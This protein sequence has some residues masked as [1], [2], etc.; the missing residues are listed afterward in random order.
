MLGSRVNLGS[1]ALVCR[2]LATTLNSGVSVERAFELAA[3]KTR[4]RRC[5]DVMQDVKDRV[6][7]GDDIATAMRARPNALPGLMIDLVEVG[8]KTGALPEILRNVAEH[9]ENNLRLRRSFYQSIAWPV[10]QLIAAILV[11]AGVIWLLGVI[12]SSRGGDPIDVLGLGLVG[13]SGAVIWL[14]A[15]FGTIFA[16]LVSYRIAASALEG[17]MFL[18]SLLMHIPVVGGCMR[19]FALARFAWA[20]ALTQQAGMPIKESLD[21]SL[22]ATNNGAFI[23]V[24]PT[25]W[26]LVKQGEPLAEAMAEVGVFPDDF[27]QIVEVAESS[28]TVP[29]ALERLSGQLEED[30][31]RS[32]A[33]LTAVLGWGVWLIVAIFIIFI[34]FNM[35]MRVYIGP[36]YEALDQT[37]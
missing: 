21:A 36:L 12:A 16:L 2:S 29:E 8:E 30:A 4:D 13:S 35:V 32:L 6:R 9:F 22:R 5:R 19:S 33:A 27:V 10:F 37:M 1:L 26:G 25:L 15:T 28:G 7:R 17:K 14:T 24:R 18:H 31:R 34:I 20:F 3:G 23:K 11:I